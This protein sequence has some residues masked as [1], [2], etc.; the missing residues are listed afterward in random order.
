M[1]LLRDHSL[2]MSILY[3]LVRRSDLVRQKNGLYVLFVPHR[4]CAAITCDLLK[5]PHLQVT[6][7]E[8]MTSAKKKSN[9]STFKAF[10]K[11]H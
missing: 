1:K 6:E 10:I 7:K 5:I 8:E 2:I 11:K 9:Q 3:V 4:T